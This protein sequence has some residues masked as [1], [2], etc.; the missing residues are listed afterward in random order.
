MTTQHTAIV[1]P[2]HWAWTTDADQLHAL[3][4]ATPNGQE[5]P[6]ITARVRD[7]VEGIQLVHLGSVPATWSAGAPT[8]GIVA[9]DLWGDPERPGRIWAVDTALGLALH[10]AGEVCAN[11]STETGHQDTPVVAVTDGVAV[12]CVAPVLVH[13]WAQP[14]TE[15]AIDALPADPEAS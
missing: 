6:T 14:D 2:D 7:A 15:A 8:T 3:A 10:H 9:L 1:V 11:P 13:P 4:V 5:Q 12:A